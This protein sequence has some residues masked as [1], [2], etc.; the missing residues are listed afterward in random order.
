MGVKQ[1]SL[2]PFKGAT[3]QTYM[4]R[5]I[6]THSPIAAWAQAEA[7]GTTVVESVNGWNGVYTS[8]TVNDSTGPDGQPVPRYD[9]LND[10]AELHSAGLEGAIDLSTGT[11]LIWMKPFNVGV[12][13]DGTNRGILRWEGS[14]G[15]YLEVMRMSQDNKLR[16]R[17]SFGAFNSHAEPGY[18]FTDWQLVGFSW[19]YSNPTTTVTCWAEA[20]SVHS[21]A[22]VGEPTAP[23]TALRVGA[24]GV[25]PENVFNGWLGPILVFDRVLSGDDVA[26]IGVAS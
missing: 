19:S 21:I 8:A 23:I 17:G 3:V 9:G 14:D 15:H 1:Q 11:A 25:A 10:K 2:I 24:Q 20:V 7:S 18:S 5:V 16:W 13:T 26:D 12:W 6:A 4:Q 22:Y